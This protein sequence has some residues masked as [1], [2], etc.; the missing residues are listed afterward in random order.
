M[1]I[2]R[3][4]IVDDEPLALRR[5]EQLLAPMEGFDVC[6]SASGC[7]DAVEAT[8]R[9]MPD[10]V[11]LDIRMRDGSGFDYLAA[12]P[13]D[14]CPAVIFVTAFDSHAVDAFTHNA[15][16]YVLKPIDA[17]RLGIALGRAR[18]AIEERSRAGSTDE[19]HEVIANLRAK[20]RADSEPMFETEIW[21]RKNVTGFVRVLVSDIQSI[22]AEDDYVRIRTAER[23]YLLRST[24]ND[25][26]T[27]LDPGQFMRIHRSALIRRSSVVEFR[28]DGPGLH[29][30]LA[31]GDRLRVGRVYA[32]L[33]K[34]E[35]TRLER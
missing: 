13:E 31:N 8:I 2:V 25:V 24:L 9:E 6:A 35:L 33:I 26:Q 27:K 21:I 4:L 16:D 23:T 19:L 34:P 11:L 10:V 3:V 1:T 20:I 17:A 15:L 29:A 14:C 30:C 12:L 7:S 28:R 32:K 5:L 22:T 18:R